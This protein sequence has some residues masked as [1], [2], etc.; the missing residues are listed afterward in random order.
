M[1]AQHVRIP[2]DEASIGGLLARPEVAAVTIAAIRQKLVR[3]ISMSS[4]LIMRFRDGRHVKTGNLR[5][6]T[7]E[8]RHLVSAPVELSDELEHDALRAA[9]RAWR[10][11]FHRRGDLGDT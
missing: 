10:D 5:I 11:A 2:R 3:G 4:P 6:A 8:G 9:V 1:P 7:G